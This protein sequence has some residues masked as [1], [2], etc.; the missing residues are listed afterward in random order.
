[1]HSTDPDVTQ[2]VSFLLVVADR[3]RGASINDP[4]DQFRCT[5]G[6]TLQ[7][8]PEG[9]RVAKSP[10]GP[11]AI[12]SIERCDPLLSRAE[13][14]KFFQQQQNFGETL[15]APLASSLMLICPLQTPRDIY[16]IHT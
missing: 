9:F 1:M 4:E 10:S 14:R 16:K 8:C 6:D 12:D 15:V 7:S 11:Q 5:E 13:A 3:I 2:I